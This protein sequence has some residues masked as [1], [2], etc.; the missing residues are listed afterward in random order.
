MKTLVPKAKTI[1]RNWQLFDAKNQIL[2]RLA[3]KIA[4]C[5]M[6]KSKPYFTR[7][8]DCG[9]YAVVINAKE[10]LTTGKK[11]KQKKYYRH[12]GYPKGLK[13]TN[14]AQ[15]RQE[16]PER[17]IF[18]AVSGMLPQNK[19]KDKML[20]RLYIFSDANHPYSNKFGEKK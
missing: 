14:L 19:L 12:S 16:H 7:N 1:Q 8:T 15:L 17:I 11:E 5:L 20:T 13:V 9:D 6:G 18:H 3:V 4:E 10:I 2:G